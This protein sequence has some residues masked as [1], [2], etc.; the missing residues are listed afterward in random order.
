MHCTNHFCW[1]FGVTFRKE[2]GLKRHNTTVKHLLEV[3]RFKECTKQ[4]ATSTLWDL[5]PEKERDLTF[6]DHIDLVQTQPKPEKFFRHEPEIYNNSKPIEIPLEKKG[7]TSDQRRG[8][9]IYRKM[10]FTP[11]KIQDKGSPSS[12][13]APDTPD[14]PPFII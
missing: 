8:I 5:T 9:E 4:M 6:I 11:K 2:S 13:P 10:K 12:Y 1:T 7:E 14:T 3:K